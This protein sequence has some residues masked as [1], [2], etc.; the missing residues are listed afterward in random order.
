MKVIATLLVLASLCGCASRHKEKSGL[1]GKSLPSFNLFLSDS[2]TH[3]NTSQIPTGKP[4]VLFFF[5]PYCPYSRA[6]MA[7]IVDHMKTL[8]EIQF[9]V[10]TTAQFPD[11][12]NFYKEY[13]LQKYRNIVVGIDYTNFFGSYF[14]A[15]GVPYLAVYD[16]Q[17]KLKEVLV[18]KS[19]VS[20]L[21]QI[22]SE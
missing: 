11:M 13:Q 4:V 1:E 18:G 19:D 2:T 3:F 10:F 17:K 16:A 20:V 22:A 7:D 5:G 21:K 9:Y 12:K 8:Q 6:E 14:K 15:P